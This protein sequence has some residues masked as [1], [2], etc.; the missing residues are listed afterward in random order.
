[1]SSADDSTGEVLG[2]NLVPCDLVATLLRSNTTLSL[3]VISVTGI[4][5]GIYLLVL[6][7]MLSVMRNRESE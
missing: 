1:M 6:T 7:S 2:D 3:A 4:H 5:K